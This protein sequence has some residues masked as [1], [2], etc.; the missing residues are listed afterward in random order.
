M[1][2]DARY[3]QQMKAKGVQPIRIR[4]EG[5]PRRTTGWD[6][7]L[8]DTEY[9]A[10]PSPESRPLRE[11]RPDRVHDRALNEFA[12]AVRRPEPQHIKQ[13]SMDGTKRRKLQHMYGRKPSGLNSSSTRPSSANQAR[14]PTTGTSGAEIYEIPNFRDSPSPPSRLLG[15][16]T[17]NIA[18]PSPAV[19][20]KPRM[21]NDEMA[22][23]LR[24]DFSSGS[25]LDATPKPQAAAGYP[26]SRV[27]SVSSNESSWRRKDS[28]SSRNM[29]ES[30]SG[31]A[32]EDS[33]QQ[34]EGG[35]KVVKWFRKRGTRGVLPASYVRFAE[36]SKA[37]SRVP[38]RTAVSP[39]Q[40]EHR[41][42]IA[43]AKISNRPREQIQ[44]SFVN[45]DGGSDS[46]DDMVVVASG[47]VG[48]RQ[49]EKPTSVV[50]QRQ[51]ISLLDDYGDIPEDNQIDY[52]LP[53]K[54]RR[55][56]ATKS[57]KAGT[58][59]HG[60]AAAGQ[61]SRHQGHSNTT[62]APR[63]RNPRKSSGPR[64]S[65]VDAA[66][67]LRQSGNKSPPKF[68]KVAARSALARKDKGRQS[69]ARKLFVLDTAGDTREVQDIL[70]NWREGT[71][72][73]GGHDPQP[74]DDRPPVPTQTRLASPHRFEDEQPL[75][76]KRRVP[77]FSRATKPRQTSLLHHD[78][79]MQTQ[80]GRAQPSKARP[81][82]PLAVVPLQKGYI[83]HRPAFAPQFAQFERDVPSSQQPSRQHP[84][85]LAI[86]SVIQNIHQ[87]RT[88]QRASRNLQAHSAH[89]AGQS[90]AK[91]HIPALQTPPPSAPTAQSSPAPRRPA[92]RRK[93]VTP[94]RIDA[95]TIER[96]QPPSQD[97]IVDDDL[98]EPINVEGQV[99]KDC[100]SGLLP[101]GSKYSLN[102]DTT[103]LKDGTIFN[104]S[105]FIGQGCLSLALHTPCPRASAPRERECYL[106]GETAIC[107]GVYDDTVATEF[108]KVLGMIGAAAEKHSDRSDVDASSGTE[109]EIMPVLQAY[110][111]YCFVVKYINKTLS[112]HDPLDAV[113]FAQRFVQSI[114]NCCSRLSLPVSGP[115][116]TA[117]ISK[118]HTRLVLQANAFLLV[119]SFQIF[120]LCSHNADLQEQLELPHTLRK[121][122]REL[123]SRLF[124]CGIDR[125]RVCY[126]D[127]RRRIHFERGITSDHYIVELWVVGIQILDKVDVTGISFWNIWNDEI[128][129]QRVE[130]SIDVKYFERLWRSLFTLLPLHQFDEFGVSRRV[131]DNRPGK[132]NWALIKALAGRPLKIYDSNKVGHSTMI[133]DYLRMIYAR[134][135]HLITKWS[136][137]NPDSIIPVLFE[138]FASNGLANLSNEHDKGSP[139]FLLNLDKNPTI[140]ADDSDRCFHLLLKTIV[141]GL[142]RMR[143]T[144]TFRKINGL[145]YRLMPNHRRQ[146]PK[147]EDLHVEHLDALKNHH[148]LL[149]ALHWAAPP[150]CRPPLDAI[151]LLV[152]PETSHRQACNV[153]VRA[154]T[155]L[156]RFQLHSGESLEPLKQ[157]MEWF[158]DLTM[159][160]LGQH[161][162]VR[163]E[164]ER[165][166]RLAQENQDSNLSEE[167]MEE[168]IKRNQKQLEAILNDLVKSLCMELATIPGNIPNAVA[169][170]TSSMSCY[171]LS[172]KQN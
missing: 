107:W 113:S 143:T 132:D 32:A 99:V 87:Q 171:I 17:S 76:Y 162:L 156:M 16:R 66:A 163:S 10:P 148:Y 127:Q 118:D 1:L 138:F 153:A 25:D 34:K 123:L 49:V 12:D 36:G 27:I 24:Y 50:H 117:A 144:S 102:F 56:I 150:D 21:T 38:E 78:F 60:Q 154:W 80:P 149:E 97:L 74:R 20:T 72:P 161:H 14:P 91:A 131:D 40:D 52:G 94:R 168:N 116:D 29:S 159:K 124:R 145:V 126:E 134:C 41:P 84:T 18:L 93:K 165:Q 58:S 28:L 83:T 35:G 121:I 47:P 26:R 137:I 8:Q 119:I 114:E 103:P 164:A 65:I 81:A 67:H 63:K 172:L 158:D 109:T 152:D 85:S 79:Q 96:R 125:V 62:R 139:N 170:L 33:S 140:T 57:R 13:V 39:P 160:T 42:G 5:S 30:E 88:Q 61:G 141:V 122:G 15:R 19:R 44:D 112:F 136:W 53:A 166:F 7:D 120:R 89:R 68:L 82:R 151:R 105:T 77:T 55:T 133:N 129:I 71:L 106:F 146:Y 111:F 108:E 6:K 75:K 95:D 100:L 98:L 59:G 169:L 43:R 86:E 51:I 142:K 167:D 101:F 147:D 157:L 45:D 64:L 128:H 4:Q 3:K 69:P 31:S 2:E 48:E 155:N 130:S 115:S 73:F 11:L 23:L 135:Y 92:P 70:S 46:S 37:E 110:G 104:S 22:A 90:F 9:V 54:S